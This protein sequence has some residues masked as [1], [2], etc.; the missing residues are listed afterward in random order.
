MRAMRQ[1]A[2]IF[3]LC[4]SGVSAC[5]RVSQTPHNTQSPMLTL[6]NQLIIPW[7]TEFAR[8]NTTLAARIERFCQNPANPGEYQEARSAWQAS[9][10]AWQRIS[11]LHFGPIENDNLRTT[12]YF[13]PDR[14]NW[15]AK[16]LSNRLNQRDANS[17]EF[18]T[19]AAQLGLAEIEYLLF[20]TLYTDN[21]ALAGAPCD[22]LRAAS[23]QL[24]AHA[25]VLLNKWQ[26]GEDGVW[27]AQGLTIG[28]EGET[29]ALQAIVSSLITS[30]ERITQEEL[31]AP[32][33]HLTQPE[34]KSLISQA[35]RANLGKSAL[36]TE[37]KSA[38]SLIHVGLQPLLNT[39]SQQALQRTLIE[40]LNQLSAELTDTPGELVFLIN[41]E[42]GRAQLTQ[43]AKHIQKM[44]AN[45]HAISQTLK[46]EIVQGIPKT[47]RQ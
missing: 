11:I 35:W 17:S 27:P 29:Q 13:W 3:L 33:D 1:Y 25:Q 22:V 31:I 26:T 37:L 19:P 4:L 34:A 42:R 18:N 38:H 28:S 46:G 5:D 47:S 15:V 7:H 30:F 45:L 23:N 2:C 9:F 6:R 32:I 12:L 20:D 41:T 10:I 36:L 24:N 44:L 43:A 8:A 39:P 21:A 16:H 40:D 14:F